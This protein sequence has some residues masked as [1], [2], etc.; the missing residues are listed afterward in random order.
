MTHEAAQEQAR[1][2]ARQCGE[3]VCVIHAHDPMKPEAENDYVILLARVAATF[4]E[5]GMLKASE[6]VETFKEDG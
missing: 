1:R 4:R 6:I 2:W 3:A 5:R